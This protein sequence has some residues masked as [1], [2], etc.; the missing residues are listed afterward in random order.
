[1]I[2]K[3]ML[4]G[5]IAVFLA[6]SPVNVMANDIND[7]S[8]WDSEF[9]LNKTELK[10]DIQENISDNI[11]SQDNN[12]ITENISNNIFDEM[13]N[14]SDE[15]GDENSDTEK[16]D[17]IS[18]DSTAPEETENRQWSFGETNFDKM[19]EEINAGTD[20]IFSLNND[21]LIGSS[22]NAAFS[23]ALADAAETGTSSPIS[24]YFTDGTMASIGEMS[25]FDLSGTD[26]TDQV[27]LGLLN[28]QYDSLATDLIDSSIDLSGSSISATELF[29]NTYGDLAN[30]LTLEKPQIP[31]SF[32]SRDMIALGQSVINSNRS[33]FANSSTYNNVLSN[34]NISSLVS[35]TKNG[36]NNTSL[37]TSNLVSSDI[38]KGMLDTASLSNEAEIS[39]EHE[40]RYQAYHTYMADVRDE[41]S[42]AYLGK[43][44]DKILDYIDTSDNLIYNMHENGADSEEVQEAQDKTNS[45]LAEQGGSMGLG[46]VVPKDYSVDSE[47]GFGNA[48]T[49]DIL[50]NLSGAYSSTGGDALSGVIDTI[51]NASWDLSHGNE[52]AV[53]QDILKY[54][55]KTD[56]T[57][58]IDDIENMSPAEKAKNIYEMGLDMYG[59]SSD[60]T[61]S[62]VEEPLIEMVQASSNQE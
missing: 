16:T 12:K 62:E 19:L 48:T 53:N 49:Q 47:N 27:D 51:N 38:L 52:D 30:E 4:T 33:V 25:Y 35:T 20:S 29:Y 36:L 43:E 13:N 9:D 56:S 55:Q 28:M 42:S 61:W 31:E 57:I 17:E 10:E 14:T 8:S 2:E 5:I 45:Y 24:D 34:I 11:S 32:S 54:R 50:S 40:Q 3:R 58:T 1:M 6:A 44:L 46:D 7:L 60:P 18:E 41:S 37:S 22:L 21:S 23:N 15:S 59:T 26:L 39:S